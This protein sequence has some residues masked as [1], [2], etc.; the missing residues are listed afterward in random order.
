MLRP[1]SLAMSCAALQAMVARRGAVVIGTGPHLYDRYVL[2]NAFC[3]ITQETKV[4]FIRAADTPSCF[5]GYTC[6]ER[7]SVAR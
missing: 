5:V 2:N 3:A 1:D 7:S 6:L 4:N